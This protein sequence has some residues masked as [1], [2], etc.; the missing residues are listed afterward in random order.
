V[1]LL[2]LLGDYREVRWLAHRPLL[3][4]LYEKAASSGM[5]W[6]KKRATEL[7]A[8]VAESQ[9]DP[10]AA[11]A[12]FR[13]AIA[14]ISIS[15][16]QE[17]SGLLSF[18]DIQR[19]L[20][21][22]VAA[23]AWMQWAEDRH[24]IIRGAELACSRCG[25]KTWRPLADIAGAVCPGCGQ[26]GRHPFNETALPFR[27]RLSEPLRRAIE[28]DSIYHL[29]VMRHLI[30][31]MS[32]RDDWL[33][34]A[35]PGVD[36]YSAGGAQIGEADVLLLFAD[37]TTLPVEVKRHAGGFKTGDLERLDAIADQMSAIGTVLGCGDDSA[38]AGDEFAELSL[39]EP[40]PRRLITADQWL[41]PRSHPVMGAPAGSE[42]R[43]ADAGSPAD[44]FELRFAQDIVARL[45]R[46]DAGDPVAGRLGLDKRA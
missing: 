20:K 41:A 37:G 31:F 19:V 26:P 1:A 12:D 7:A 24:L 39:E 17:S 33:V 11:L 9:A 44:A 14:G 36:F 35:H 28:N 6:F 27:F 8:R 40:R 3:K 45:P 43:D 29:L 21:E 22:R 2:Q 16:D 4:L 18:S 13:I 42:P 5:T 34:G 10:D 23:S 30:D 46:Q 32:I 25:A 15:T 38:A